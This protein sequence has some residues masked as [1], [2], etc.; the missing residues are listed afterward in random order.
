MS[1]V[2]PGE[3]APLGATVYST[4]VNFSLFSK[5]ASRVDLLL[6]DG[7]TD[8]EPRA[9]IPL[10]PRRHRTYHYWHVFVPGLVPG[11]VYAYRAQGPFLPEQG[12]RFD[13]EKIL[14]DPYGLSV[15]VPEG[16]DRLAAARPGDN[17]AVA[18]KSVVAA[19][20]AYD[21]EGDRPLRRPFAETVIYELHARGFTA[22]PTS[23]VAPEKRG[24]YA[25]L[26]EK[27]P[28]LV[29]LGVTAIEL[30][31]VFQFDPQTA[32]PGLVNYWGYQPVSFFAP[33][34]AYSSRKEPLA[35][36]DEFRDLVK[37]LHRAGIEVILDVV[38]NHTAEGD[39]NGP[40]LSYRGLANESYYLLQQDRRR[41]ADFTGTGNTLNANQSIVRRL[42]QDSLRYWVTEMHVDGFRF[43]LASI[44]SR[45]ESGRPLSSPPVLWDI[46]SD[47]RLAGTKLIA[48]AWDAAGLYQVG[49]FVGDAWLEWNG[50]F[51]DD[52]RR[53]LKGDDRS[54]SGLACRLLGSPD[55]YG[56]EQRESEQS[57][58][59]VTCHDGFTLDDLVSYDRKHNE[60][61][62]EE[63]RDG[64]NDNLS[65]N[66][67]V[68]GP[69][70][71]PAIE[72]LRNR[73]VKNFL[74][75]MMLSAGTP[76]LLMGDELRRTQRGNNNAYCQ[77]NEISWFDWSLLERHADIHRFVKLLNRFR[78]RREVVT[79]Q[80][81]ALSLN[82]LLRRARI[83]WHG[84][85]LGEPDW[86]DPSHS[87]A[88]TLES[89]HARFLFHGMLNAY[90]EPLTFDL[91]AVPGSWRRSI[92]TSLVS[93]ADFVPWEEAPFVSQPNYTVQPRSVVILVFPANGRFPSGRMGRSPAVIVRRTL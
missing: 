58:N 42:I 77:D 23:D 25:G 74:T 70:G 19:P 15:A 75:L 37:A 72:A 67:G 71:D 54:V 59:F 82:E 40:T 83:D 87:L 85:V 51:R 44:L 8:E 57:I 45:D 11:Q 2:G 92:D 46:E 66:C 21:W 89:L 79:Q 81:S 17:A 9:V 91:P 1:P 34:H 93:P 31:P 86:S 14:L 53:F 61:N 26:I 5:H 63:N 78:Q 49:S 29:D 41:Y 12:L 69:T 60:A 30:L 52:V 28:Y 50:R 16:Y 18:M 43:D 65:W 88:F 90:W 47:P 33:H 80:G 62:G 7:A 38:F 76:M 22:H 6:F 55:L 36:L 39:E 13:G 27:I 48:E 84:V 64:S 20:G 4:G 35:V 73:Q 56:H 3:S 24:T 32:P 68:E 10:D